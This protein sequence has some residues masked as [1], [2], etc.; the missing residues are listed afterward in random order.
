L[1]HKITRPNGAIEI[2]LDDKHRYWLDGKK[3]SGGTKVA[4]RFASPSFSVAANW[5]GRCAGNRA[6]ELLSK[7][8]SGD[9]QLNELTIEKMKKSISNSHWSISSEARE[10]GS[11][12]HEALENLI[13]ARMDGRETPQAPFHTGAQTAFNSYLAW[14]EENQP[15]YLGS[16]EVIYYCDPKTGRDYTGTLDLVFKLKGVLCVGDFKTSKIFTEEMIAQVALYATAYEQCHGQK[17]KQLFIFRLPKTDDGTMEI[18]DFDF[19]PTWRKFCR[20][21]N[22]LDHFQR[23]IST[24]LKDKLKE[25]RKN[26]KS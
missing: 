13:G 1:L 5:A 6:G 8:M 16:E 20:S 9:A 12:V 15:Q 11:L 19:T 25:L 22:E 10:T 7:V 23:Q 18:I 24:D 14:E 26:A 21:M 2:D 4:Q 3:L 17:V